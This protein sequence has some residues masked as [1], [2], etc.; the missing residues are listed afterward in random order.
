MIKKLQ[1]NMLG[2][3]QS[4]CA[5]AIMA[6]VSL[7][8]ADSAS[9]RGPVR[10][11]P[12]AAGAAGAARVA[13]RPVQERGNFDSLR[14]LRTAP[15][16]VPATTGQAAGTAARAQGTTAPQLNA[17]GSAAAGGPPV[18]FRG[19][20]PTNAAQ[21][22][23]PWA[24]AGAGTAATAAANQ[25]AVCQQGDEN[26]SAMKDGELNAMS[27]IV[28]LLRERVMQGASIGTGSLSAQAD[29]HFSAVVEVGY[30]AVNATIKGEVAAY[31]GHR[32]G[33]PDFYQTL[34]VIEQAC[35]ASAQTCEAE[36]AK[37]AND[38]KLLRDQC[39]ALGV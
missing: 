21:A 22:A 2:S 12:G 18:T 35:G 36:V 7:T 1:K 29:A 15:G 4:L 32:D 11:N 8:V 34:Q 23:S 39:P 28:G 30:G 6:L 31:K 20:A 33:I 16:Q 27:D 38:L 17:G 10:V 9:A 25:Q 24:A 26:C 5:V 3:K 14:G 13:P 19:A 37:A